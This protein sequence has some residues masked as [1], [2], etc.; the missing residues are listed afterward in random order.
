[1]LD[2]ILIGDARETLATVP[3]GSLHLAVTSIP[4]WAL[5][6]YA[7]LGA[8]VWGGRPDCAH[9]WGTEQPR[10][11][12]EN[13]NGLGA[14]SEFAGRA[15][16][17]EINEAANASTGGQYCRLC[18]AWRG[19]WGNEPTLAQYVANTVEF[20]RAVRRVLRDDGVFAL[21]LGDS[22]ANSR[23][24][25][26]SPDGP[27]RGRANASAEREQVN[28][29]MGTSGLKP[30]DMCGVPWRV[31]LALQADGWYLRR[32][33]VWAKGLSFCDTY[34]GSVMPESISPPR[35]EKHRI[36]VKKAAVTYGQGNR[37]S[38][39]A[40]CPNPAS[41][42]T[43]DRQTE[44][45]ECPGCD[46]CNPT[47]GLVLRRGRW[48]PTSAHELIFLLT[49]SEHYHANAEAVRECASGDAH[50]QGAGTGRKSIAF[51]NGVRANDDFTTEITSTVVIANSG[52]VCAKR[53]RLDSDVP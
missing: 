50:A 18:G 11:G 47:G 10:A 12:N 7:G 43:A 25:G 45:R 19:C 21:N 15:D 16:K 49:K 38:D 48:R 29:D 24:G 33:I 42:G 30:G 4:Y 32:A 37:Y 35:W 31:A 22:M 9:E 27:R 51:G 39:E 17:A 52:N 8:S 44:W 36:K 28:R 23:C 5:R 41:H 6:K 14:N 2:T 1:M 3:E 20:F 26:G 13:R 40:C 46:K 34:S 53:A